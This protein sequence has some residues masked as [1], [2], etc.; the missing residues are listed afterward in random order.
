[1][2]CF[3]VLARTLCVGSV[4][5][6]VEMLSKFR[7]ACAAIFLDESGKTAIIK[8][9]LVETKYEK[10]LKDLKNSPT[11][12]GKPLF[13]V[14]EE[15]QVTTESVV[16]HELV[17]WV[18]RHGHSDDDK[19]KARKI[20]GELLDANLLMS[21]YGKNENVFANYNLYAW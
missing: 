10:L 5:V 20:V 16:G 17:E 8:G 14:F 2:I 4:Q 9:V 12:L 6:M 1:M 11:Y 19:S 7:Q 3:S 13:R 18:L 15:Y 21:T